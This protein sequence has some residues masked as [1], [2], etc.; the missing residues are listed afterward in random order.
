MIP[1]N[2]SAPVFKPAPDGAV[3]WFRVRWVHGVSNSFAVGGYSSIFLANHS[4]SPL[5]VP[6]PERAA[7]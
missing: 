6:E 1:I 2:L 3:V 7:A 5:A 4:F